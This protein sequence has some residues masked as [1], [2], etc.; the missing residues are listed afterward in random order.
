[1]G[2]KAGRKGIASRRQESAHS[3]ADTSSTTPKKRAGVSNRQFVIGCVLLIAAFVVVAYGVNQLGWFQGGPVVLKDADEKQAKSDDKSV[4]PS[5]EEHPPGW[6][7]VGGVWRNPTDVSGKRQSQQPAEGVKFDPGRAEPVKPDANDQVKSMVEAITSGKF[8]ERL[9]PAAAPKPFDA[10]AYEKDPQAYLSIVEP[11]RVFQPAQPGPGV[12]H[13][14]RLGDE[15]R[16]IL[17]GE[18]VTLQVVVTPDAPVYFTSFDLGA[19]ENQLPTISVKA[20]D[21]GLAEAQFTGTRGTFNDVRIL[22]ASPVTSGRATFVVN[23]AVPE[24]IAKVDAKA[25]E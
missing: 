24:G 22:A 16:E 17:Q 3:E 11:G 8:P 7:N 1:M 9:S 15:L 20:D 2:K 13:I 21:K 19:F 23:V 5:V 25:A 12:K 18:T 6:V 4:D 10:V 14:A